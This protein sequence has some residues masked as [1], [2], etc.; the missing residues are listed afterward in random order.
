MDLSARK[1]NIDVVVVLINLSIGLFCILQIMDDGA[2]ST[3]EADLATQ[4]VRSIALTA[5]QHNVLNVTLHELVIEAAY[6]PESSADAVYI[7]IRMD[8]AAALQLQ[9]N[10]EEKITKKRKRSVDK[11]PQG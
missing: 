11:N 4:G 8:P 3:M 7:L 2:F 1:K 10:Q 6:N 9:K 5:I